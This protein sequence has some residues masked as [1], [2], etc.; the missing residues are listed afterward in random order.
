MSQVRVTSEPQRHCPC[1]QAPYRLTVLVPDKQER[2][3]VVCEFIPAPLCALC[4]YLLRVQG[5]AARTLDRDGET[6]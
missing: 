5:M 4:D 3:A 1:C 2:V 6:R